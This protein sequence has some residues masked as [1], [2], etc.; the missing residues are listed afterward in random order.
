MRGR[1]PLIRASDGARWAVP[2][3]HQA[4]VIDPD[5]AARLLVLVDD[6]VL[7]NLGR[8]LTAAGEYDRA[9]IAGAAMRLFFETK[10]DVLADLALTQAEAARKQEASSRRGAAG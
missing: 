10:A 5:A 6:N 8:E 4:L 7:G 1:P 2:L 3:L 9:R